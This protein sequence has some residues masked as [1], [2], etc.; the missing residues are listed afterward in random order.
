MA[1]QS[2]SSYLTGKLLLAMP[3][4]GDS[5]FH[6]A[7][8]FVISHHA[9]GAMGL[10]INSPVQDFTF[11]QLMKE[12]GLADIPIKRDGVVLLN[13]GPVEIQHGFL[14]HT[15]DYIQENTI[16]VNAGLSVSASL[17]ALQAFAGGQV[18]KEGL[19]ALGY[20]GWGAGQLEQELQDN[21]WSVVDSDYEILFNT[22]LEDRWERAF[23][24]LGVDPSLM[25]HE[26]GRA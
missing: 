4:M 16:E 24:R 3:S 23:S 17:D 5:R 7:V 19:L 14:L 22:P 11:D 6:H 15:S 13:G 8:I 25:S 1:T 9:L 10:I 26:A 2:H 18:P 12:A 21:A 20:A